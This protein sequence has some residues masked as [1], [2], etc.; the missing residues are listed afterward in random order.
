MSQLCSY[1]CGL[2]LKCSFW[3]LILRD[4][5]SH[6]R[7]KP[8]HVLMSTAE[9]KCRSVWPRINSR[10]G[11]Q[12]WCSSVSRPTALYSGRL[13]MV[14][15]GH[16]LSFLISFS[17]DHN[18]TSIAVH[19]HLMRPTTP[20]NFWR[21]LDK[22]STCSSSTRA[23]FSFPLF[24]CVKLQSIPV[25]SCHR[26]HVLRNIPTRASFVRD[27]KHSSCITPIA[28]SSSMPI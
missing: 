24:I 20:L 3:F 25:A 1:S 21:L 22:S 13:R 4:T 10:T 11:T 5:N 26:Q 9:T 12:A 18:F 28:I 8:N 23:C 14:W 16:H 7:L 17:S 27:D 19:A 2:K 6:A 15:A